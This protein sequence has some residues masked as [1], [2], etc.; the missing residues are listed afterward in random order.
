MDISIG[1]SI[2]ELRKEQHMTQEQLANLACVSFQAVSKWENG[3]AL[4]DITLVPRL[5]QIFGVTTDELFAY[6]Q[7]EIRDEIEQYVIKARKHIEYDHEKGRII[8]EEALQ[9]YP[10][11][12]ILLN[13]FLYFLNYSADPDE[14]IRIA[15]KLINRTT[16]S[17]IRYDALRFLAYAYHA[18]GDTESAI[19]A[20]EQIPEIY[21]TKFSEMAFILTGKPMYEV[22]EKQKW[23]SFEIL[24][25]M[26]SKIA[27]YYEGEGE[28]E[29]AIAELERTIALISALKDEE[30]INELYLNYVEYFKRRINDLKDRN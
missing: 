7:K 20:L 5:A 30:K 13:N 8:L 22:A 17:G 4:P 3:I 16:A 12:D 1:K 25:Q 23:L 24:L 9:K 10:E 19:A 2:K 26:M 14:T 27:E 18:K 15:N 6:N 28:K 21:F 11:N 29:K